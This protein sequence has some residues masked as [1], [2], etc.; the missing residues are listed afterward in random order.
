MKNKSF[1]VMTIV[2]LFIGCNRLPNKPIYEELTINELEKA[3][4]AD[5]A[6]AEF[7]D[8]AVKED[9]FSQFTPSQKAKYKKVSWKRLFKFYKY[10]GDYEIW[11]KKDSIW[12]IQWGN[13]FAK[14]FARADSIIAYWDNYQDSCMH[15][16]SHW[17][18]IVMKDSHLESY[19]GYEWRYYDYR[20]VTKYRQIIDFEF[21][22]ADGV[23]KIDMVEYALEWFSN[24]SYSPEYQY[25][26]TDVAYNITKE[27]NSTQYRCGEN[28]KDRLKNVYITKVIIGHD[29]IK[30]SYTANDIP[31][32]IREYVLS[33][34]DKKSSYDYECIVKEYATDNFIDYWN[35]RHIKKEEDQ[36][37]YDKLVF[38]LVKEMD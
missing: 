22:L 38:E 35:Y 6:F 8:D 1:L 27:N 29:T 10:S 26:S 15:V 28:P 5:S 34:N 23:D 16:F 31:K 30:N 25:T 7:Y 9:I 33:D 18:S 17:V 14:D 3:I 21:Q 13:E 24:D 19:I 12:R 2:T 37:K 32:S 20:E 4:K 36:K 11:E